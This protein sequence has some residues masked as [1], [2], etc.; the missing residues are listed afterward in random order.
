M[1][2]GPQTTQQ[3]EEKKSSGV[4]AKMEASHDL[5]TAMEELGIDPKDPDFTEEKMLAQFKAISED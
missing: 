3:E 4:E 5:K 2:A 1:E